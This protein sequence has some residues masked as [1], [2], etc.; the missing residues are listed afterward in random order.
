M[1]KYCKRKIEERDKALKEFNKEFQKN[2]LYAL[3]WS[4]G[5]IE[6]LAMG[7]LAE[8]LLKA[9]NEGWTKEHLLTQ[10][11]KNIIKKSQWLNHSTSAISNLI[12]DYEKV[13][14]GKFLEAVELYG[15]K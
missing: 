11:R 10:I 7:N 1:K 5:L 14:E 9:L 4:E 3:K 12:E 2:P 6:T 8:R 13:T 15:E